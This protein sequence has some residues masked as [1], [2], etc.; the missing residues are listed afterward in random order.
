MTRL[1]FWGSA[2]VIFY[3]YA[4]YVAWLWLRHR[5]WPRPIHAG[6]CSS[7]I[8][9]VLVVRNAAQML[10]RKLRNLKQLS[11]PPG[12][13]EIVVV[14]DGSSD[15][16]NEILSRY[17]KDEHV[18]VILRP[19]QRGKAAGIN[20]AIA[21]T[22]GDVVVFT[23]VRQILEPTAIQLMLE[24]FADPEVGGVSG[25]LMLGD[26][27]SG[28]AAKGVGLYWRIE[29]A[30]RELESA[31]GSVVGATGAIYAVRRHL[32]VPL[33]PETVLD[34][35]YIPMHVV[36]Q[37]ARVVFE[38]R[39]RA[40]DVPD[41]GGKREFARK[42]RTLSG[43]YQLLQ[44]APW[45]LTKANP[46]RFEF[47]SHKLLRLLVPFFLAACLISSAFL[48]G[49]IYRVAF[50]TQV[51]FYAFSLLAIAHVKRGPLARIAD[52]AFTFV[53]LNTAAVVAFVNFV[54]GRKAVWIQ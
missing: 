43:N 46:V 51:A 38:A 48:P 25:E 6:P 7:A 54:S 14:S 16:T 15:G 29:K 31:S 32:L 22:R 20:D 41:Q 23:D 10:E 21:L 50:G 5:L 24:N 8:T 9:V 4:G 1:V 3:T 53:V 18:R 35:V 36:K 42:V 17:Q 33:P 34:D 47:V 19:K 39:A 45:L 13:V 37:G 40:W 2:A 11:Y 30:I 28:E 26:P 27:I 49:P 52:I 44:L 12:R